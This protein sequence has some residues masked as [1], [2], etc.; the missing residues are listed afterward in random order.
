MTRKKGD[1][2]KTVGPLMMGQKFI[3]TPW[4]V[5]KELGTSTKH[6]R[7]AVNKGLIFPAMRFGPRIAIK[8]GYVVTCVLPKKGGGVGRPKKKVYVPL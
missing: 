8:P 7:D 3:L 2:K 4:E 1:R 6:V 5:A